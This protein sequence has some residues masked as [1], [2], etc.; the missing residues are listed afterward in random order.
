MFYLCTEFDI[1]GCSDSV[2]IAVSP[3]LK[4]TASTVATFYIFSTVYLST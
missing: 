1:P 2:V 3:N 4:E